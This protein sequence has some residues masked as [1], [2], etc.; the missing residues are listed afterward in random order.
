MNIV[1]NAPTD[2]FRIVVVQTDFAPSRRWEDRFVAAS[3]RTAE[4][5]SLQSPRRS[6][7][8][9]RLLELASRSLSMYAL[10]ALA[11]PLLRSSSARQT[12]SRNLAVVRSIESADLVYLVRNDDR[13][14]LDFDPSRTVVVGSTHCD[15][16]S[17]G[18]LAFESLPARKAL[19]ALYRRF[20][21][22]PHRQH[23]GIDAYHVTQKVYWR[24]RLKRTDLDEFIPLGVDTTRFRPRPPG[25]LRNAVRFLFVGGLEPQKGIDRLLDAWRRVTSTRGELHIVGY[26]RLVGL[27]KDHARRDPRIHYH[28]ILGSDALSELYRSCD[29]F[30]LP[31][32]YETL[33]LV[34]LEALSSGLYVV[35]SASVRGVFDYFQDQGALEYL[36][37]SPLAL[38][39]RIQQLSEGPL[40]LDDGRRWALH[41]TIEAR[42]DWRPLTAD[43]FSWFRRLLEAPRRSATPA[44]G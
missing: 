23:L 12:R 28:G 22:R 33:G 10:A 16:L 31:S 14:W 6:F 21:R 8:P 34:V 40:P 15:D 30:V 20:R 1:K 7:D 9:D 5:L 2:E 19:R 3:M 25:G 37:I 29:I 4:V 17:G 24:E 13:D 42:Y 26:G 38:A 41:R 18:L 11:Q 44:R 36:E 39:R 35:A 32:R 43:L 27:V